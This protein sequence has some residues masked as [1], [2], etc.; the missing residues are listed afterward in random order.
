M[1]IEITNLTEFID[2]L[3]INNKSVSIKKSRISKIGYNYSNGE[4][5]IFTKTKKSYPFHYTEVEDPTTP[6]IAFWS[7]YALWVYVMN[8][9]GASIP[10]PTPPVVGSNIKYG[11]L[12]NWYAASDA[13]FAPDGWHVPTQ[14]EFETLV[15]SI[16]GYSF[17]GKLKE[18]GFT[19]FNSPNTSATN[20]AGFNGRGNG[21]RNE[22]GVFSSLLNQFGIIS[23][24]EDTID[25]LND[26]YIFFS[27]YHNNGSIDLIGN[28]CY[29][30]FGLGIRLIKDDSTLVDSLIDLDENTYRTTK[31][32]NQ[33]WL[34]DNW[35]CTKLSNGTSIPNVTD[36]TAWSTLATGAYCDYNNDVANVF[37]P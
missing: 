34:A 10:V 19:Y 25:I 8:M 23:T 11:R 20:E 35:A 32:G 26:S 21:Q 6:G 22:T 3:D 2:I 37:L 9:M 16:G 33:V 24:T 15:A 13:L 31:I 5:I 4:T 36:N 30:L 12:Y 1:L 28:M 27:C 17:S 7:A 14:T 29:K 18:I